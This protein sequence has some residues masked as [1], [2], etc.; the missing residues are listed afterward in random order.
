MSWRVCSVDFPL[1]GCTPV[2]SR[3][4]VT[5]AVQGVGSR[6]QYDEEGPGVKQTESERERGERERERERERELARLLC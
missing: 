1:K 5:P 3:N 2:R 4:S 6:V